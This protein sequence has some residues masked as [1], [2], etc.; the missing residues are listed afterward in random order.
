LNGRHRELRASQKTI[1]TD[2]ESIERSTDEKILVVDSSQAVIAQP[3][4]RLM[5]LFVPMFREGK[6][7]SN[8]ENSFLVRRRHTAHMSDHVAELRWDI[9]VIPLILSQCVQST[10]TARIAHIHLLAQSDR[11]HNRQ[12]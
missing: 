5:V 10:S 1:D 8:T 2:L 11:I 3:P 7:T 12:Y 4:V 9:G 6:I